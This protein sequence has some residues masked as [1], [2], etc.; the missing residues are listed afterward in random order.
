MDQFA[1]LMSKLLLFQMRSASLQ[2]SKD[3][4]AELLDNMCLG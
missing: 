3:P 1:D 2:M 4:S